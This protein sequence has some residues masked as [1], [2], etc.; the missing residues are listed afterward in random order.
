MNYDIESNKDLQ[1]F[2]I[3]K[4]NS[5]TSLDLVSANIAKLKNKKPIGLKLNTTL[6][7]E[8]SMKVTNH[9]NNSNII[10]KLELSK[11]AREVLSELNT[12]PDDFN[13]NLGK[14]K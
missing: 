13:D 1:L 7:C 6:K 12:D 2:M 10:D 9:E 5:F 11:L 4:S 14:V 3:K 8:T